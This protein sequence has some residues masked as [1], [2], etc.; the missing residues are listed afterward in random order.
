MPWNPLV[1]LCWGVYTSSTCGSYH[2]CLLNLIWGRSVLQHLKIIALTDTGANATEA[3]AK[4]WGL[5]LCSGVSE[6]KPDKNGMPHDW[7][8]VRPCSWHKE[9]WSNPP[10]LPKGIALLFPPVFHLQLCALQSLC[11]GFDAYLIPQWVSSYPSHIW[12]GFSRS[13]FYFSCLVNQTDLLLEVGFVCTLCHLYIVFTSWRLW[14]GLGVSDIRCVLLPPNIRGVL[15][16][17]Y[18]N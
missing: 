4:A 1:L 11:G 16:S 3:E 17:P 13:L 6:L 8:C 14:K 12:N 7:R 5:S 18:C 15:A 9:V 2:L 10:L